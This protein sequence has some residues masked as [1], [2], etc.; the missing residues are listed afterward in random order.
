MPIFG[1]LFDLLS[2]T[3]STT[4]GDKDADLYVLYFN[5]LIV[6]NSI[7]NLSCDIALFN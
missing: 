4:V 7:L 3:N 2:S 1:R 5:V 6:F